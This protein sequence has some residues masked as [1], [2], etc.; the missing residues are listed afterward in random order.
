[1][2]S[3]HQSVFN[4]DRAEFEK[5]LDLALG[6]RQVRDFVR[7]EKEFAGVGFGEF[8]HGF[9]AGAPRSEA[10]GLAGVCGRAL[11]DASRR[12]QEGR[13]HAHRAL[14]REHLQV[15]AGVVMSVLVDV[16]DGVRR[17]GR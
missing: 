2:S 9:V 8:H 16:D 5:L 3:R 6:L 4:Q 1:M 17:R 7:T 13:R 10:V 12:E 11:G 14:M 15:G